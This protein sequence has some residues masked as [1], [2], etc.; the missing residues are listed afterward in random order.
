M[1]NLALSVRN[2]GGGD[3]THLYRILLQRIKDNLYGW[4]KFDDK[5]RATAVT[6]LI[7]KGLPLDEFQ[8]K[9]SDNMNK[10]VFDFV[11]LIKKCAKFVLPYGFIR[12]RQR[13]LEKVNE[14]PG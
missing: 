10:L 7:Q 9:N 4:G 6:F 12:L 2:T 11:K 3:T 8:P 14:I 1:S 5:F 13:K